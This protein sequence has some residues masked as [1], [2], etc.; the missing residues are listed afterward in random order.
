MMYF[1]RAYIIFFTLILMLGVTG[2]MGTNNINSNQNENVREKMIDYMENKYND[3]FVY[4]NSFDGGLDKNQKDIILTSEKVSGEIYVGYKCENGIET[5]SDNYTQLRF[6]K[7]T[8]ST[9]ES[10]LA[11]VIDEEILVTYRIR[12]SNNNFSDTTTYDE[13]LNNDASAV[14][15]YAVVSP[16]YIVGDVDQL[17]KL[18]S[19]KFSETFSDCSVNLY[20]ASDKEGFTNYD[21]IPSWK[22]DEMKVIEFVV[23]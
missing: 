4:V 8:K 10:I 14:C 15:F 20:F 17:T 5:Y 13:F 7:E 19:E 1:K 11:Q 9:I 22:K 18:F 3:T 16:E 2:C 6:Q 21:D 23:E 12:R